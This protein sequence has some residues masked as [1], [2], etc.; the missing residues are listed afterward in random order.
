MS[1]P[2]RVLIVEDRPADAELM[3]VELRRA[4]YDPDWQRVESEADYLAR[5]DPSLDIILA[6]YSLPQFD[7]LRALH[8]LHERELDVPVIV[9]TGSFEE[10]AIE[11]LKQ[12]ANDYL[13]KDRLARLGP[14]VAYALD[15]KR[16][17]DEKRLAESALRDALKRAN[18][19][20]VEAEAASR[21]KSEFLANMS[22]EIRTPLH[23]VLGLIELT[24]NTDLTA[25]QHHHLEEAQ[26]SAEVLLEL[27][28]DILDL[29]KI[30]AERLELE[31]VDFDLERVVEQAVT[32]LASRAEAKQLELNTAI[33]PA[34]PTGLV[35]DP[36]RLRQ[37]ILNL[38]SNA[39][40]FTEQGAV[41]LTVRTEQLSE[42]GVVLH[43]AV[44][45][46]GTGIP[47]DKQ[48][49]IMESFTQADGSI[50][51]KHGGTGL[52]LA[53]SQRLVQRF[54]GRLWLESE[55]G[56]GSTFH[57]TANFQWAV[58][59]QQWAV[60][61]DAS[62]LTAH[63]PLPTSLH[64]LLA[65]D[66]LV[67]QEVT[68]EMLEHQGWRVTAVED[69]YAVVALSAEM[70]FDV[71]LMDVQMPGMDGLAATVAIRERELTTGKHVPI[72]GLTAHALADD[73]DR[74]LAAGMD[75]YLAK[76]MKMAALHAAIAQ[77]AHP[78]VAAS[79]SE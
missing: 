59:S 51:R 7:A 40:K 46:T 58:G 68:I 73:R 3:V 79:P 34:V 27:L 2:L 19:L 52:G 15:Q 75:G 50:A 10:V 53:I 37:V 65:E 67:S 56:R 11:C 9:V 21:A 57:F 12:G 77:F 76:P 16:L 36:T 74:C 66:N 24:L 47:Q 32:M 48:A 1:T 33:D 8:L 42:R 22:H 38:L 71:I 25:E 78:A 28:S 39:I 18:R 54:G 44:S 14:A 64:I 6:D 31:R 62:L 13:L 72:I 45:D 49:L 5:L 63:S 70:D 41:K 20:A 29:S 23:G 60:P 26:E 43:F 4:G 30:E 61:S 35:G 69:G 55:V 17:R